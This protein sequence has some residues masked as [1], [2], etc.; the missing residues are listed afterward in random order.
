MESEYIIS[1]IKFWLVA[2]LQELEQVLLLL[3]DSQS[4][5]REP[6]WGVKWE[7]EGLQITPATCKCISR[8][9]DFQAARAY[10]LSLI[11]CSLLWARVVLFFFSNGDNLLR[12]ALVFFILKSFGRYLLFLDSVLAEAILFSLNTV[13]TFAI[14]FLTALILVSFTYGCDETLLTLRS[15]SSF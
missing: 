4:A 14:D 6:R 7:E 1:K 10:F 8:D 12:K 15:A 3:Y 5:G 13:S 9:H 2:S 11:D